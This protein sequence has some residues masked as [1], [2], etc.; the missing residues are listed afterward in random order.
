V[1]TLS[2]F[3]GKGGSLRLQLE[4][5][6]TDTWDISAI[7]VTLQFSGTTAQTQKINFT[8]I[9]PMSNDHTELLLYFGTDFKQR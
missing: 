6:N 3:T 1:V 7:E 2:E 9:A 5:N 8:G 4:P